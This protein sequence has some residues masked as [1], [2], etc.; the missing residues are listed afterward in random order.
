MK[1]GLAAVIMVF[2]MFAVPGTAH[3]TQKQPRSMAKDRPKIIHRKPDFQHGKDK[4]KTAK[5]KKYKWK[6]TLD[7][8]GSLLCYGAGFGEWGTDVPIVVASGVDDFWTE[9]SWRG[10]VVVFRKG[11]KYH[12]QLLRYDA[13][14]VVASGELYPGGDVAGVRVDGRTYGAHIYFNLTD[15]AQTTYSI[16]QH[17]NLPGKLEKGIKN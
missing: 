2:L 5:Y 6:V 7:K 9:G 14:N 13:G 15:G 16:W 12:T 8:N 17:P 1:R 11:N 4:T 10:P 3:C